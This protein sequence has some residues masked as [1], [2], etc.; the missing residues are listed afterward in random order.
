MTLSS[1]DKTPPPRG[2]WTTTFHHTDPQRHV[3]TVVGSLLVP[4]SAD[5]IPPITEAAMCSVEAAISLL[6]DH[7]T[8]PDFMLSF[9]CAVPGTPRAKEADDEA[10]ALRRLVVAGELRALLRVRS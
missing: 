2:G 1:R 7:L 6:A 9:G 5:D 3:H 8:D 10:A 4:R